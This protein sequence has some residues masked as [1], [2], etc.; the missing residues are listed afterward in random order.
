MNDAVRTI[1]LDSP[2]Q[3]WERLF[4]PIHETLA[5]QKGVP[6]FGKHVLAEDLRSF[7]LEQLDFI[8]H[9]AAAKGKSLQILEPAP[10]LAYQSKESNY[11]RQQASL[12]RRREPVLAG[13]GQI[14]V[15]A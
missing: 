15:P 13:A 9:I 4:R 11:D 7:L 10:Q 5:K 3:F 1:H 14:L 2:T 6:S 8:K 12:G